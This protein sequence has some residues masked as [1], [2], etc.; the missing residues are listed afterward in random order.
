MTREQI[1]ATVG[2]L[3]AMAAS[4]DTNR[5]VARDALTLL[6]WMADKGDS[7]PDDAVLR[8]LSDLDRERKAVSS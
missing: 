1:R 8:V 4:I 6:R 5:R 2:S 3:M 7:D